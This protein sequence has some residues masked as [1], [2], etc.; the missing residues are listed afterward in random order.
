MRGFT[1][2]EVL[3]AL[4]M[5]VLA[6][7]AEALRAAERARFLT[8]N[9]PRIRDHIVLLGLEPSDLFDRIDA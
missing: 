8:G 4:G 3:I 2:L 9:W 1:L 7:A 5:F 6:G